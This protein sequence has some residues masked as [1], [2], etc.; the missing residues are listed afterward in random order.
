MEGPDT[1][2]A[3]DLDG[4][5][6]AEEAFSGEPFL[7]EA[8]CLGLTRPLVKLASALEATGPELMVESIPCLSCCD[9][10]S[11]R[12]SCPLDVLRENVLS[13]VADTD[14]SDTLRLT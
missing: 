7:D 14:V 10:P 4:D 3:D 13:V 6:L 9:R 2:L 1:P 5:T 8:F 12:L 11:S